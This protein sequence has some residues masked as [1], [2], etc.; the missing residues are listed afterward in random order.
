[1]R[2]CCLGT[3]GPRLA[4]HVI[5]RHVVGNVR[6]IASAS[7]PRV[8]GT[9]TPGF[10]VHDFP[11][12]LPA[13]LG[14]SGQKPK[15]LTF[16]E[17]V[18]DANKPPCD[19]TTGV[20]TVIVWLDKSLQT[21]NAA[22][23]VQGGSSC[24]EWSAL[25]RMSGSR[26]L[27]VESEFAPDQQTRATGKA[28]DAHRQA[29]AAPDFASL[30]PQE[31]SLNLD[32]AAVLGAELMDAAEL[33]QRGRGGAMVCP[34]AVSIVS[35]DYCL[36]H[37]RVNSSALVH[38]GSSAA[39]TT[40]CRTAPSLLCEASAA[41]QQMQGEWKVRRYRLKE[42]AVCAECGSVACHRHVGSL[43]TPRMRPTKWD[44]DDIPYYP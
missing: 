18:D 33:V 22:Q 43:F 35:P 7:I 9:V 31:A 3:L 36:R 8:L 28:A 42:G 14:C 11:V 41:L 40:G 24:L 13:D 20:W 34:V 27:L 44:F 29:P 15:R 16:H 17:L 38:S 21:G 23:N 4:S 26:V 39:D 12:R 37:H 6:S 19:L 30:D 2:P 10:M 5:S 1:M 32:D 25:S